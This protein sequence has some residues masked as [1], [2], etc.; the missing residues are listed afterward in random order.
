MKKFFMLSIILVALIS[1]ATA[2]GSYYNLDSGDD[3]EYKEKISTTK[4]FPRE[5]QTVTVTRYR[6]YEN[7]DRFST[8]DYRHGYSYRTTQNYWDRQDDKGRR[9]YVRTYSRRDS[10]SDYYYRYIPYLKKYERA[11][12]YNHP[13]DG[14]LFYIECP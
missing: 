7:E 10:G 6:N 13:P 9:R 8:Y 11:K 2:H 14:K 4:Y 3:Y 12:C 1:F 5:D